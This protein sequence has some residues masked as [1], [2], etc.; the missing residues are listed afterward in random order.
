MTVDLTN[1]SIEADADVK[2]DSNNEV[3]INNKNNDE[4]E[5]TFDNGN[6]KGECTPEPNGEDRGQIDNSI[7]NTISKIVNRTTKVITTDYLNF[8]F[9][10]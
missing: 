1:S 4:Q 8:L 5:E 2:I 3:I 7:F 9:V 6:N 10:K